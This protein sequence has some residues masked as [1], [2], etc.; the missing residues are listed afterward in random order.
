MGRSISQVM[1]KKVDTVHPKTPLTRV[2][3]KMTE[4]RNKSFP[5]VEEDRI[6][7]IVAREDVLKA[8]RLAAKGRR[9]ARLA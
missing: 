5:V 6:V 2:L 1:T 4:T 8:L 7:G 9:P 3:Q